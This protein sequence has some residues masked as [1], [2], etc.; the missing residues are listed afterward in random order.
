M[1]KEKTIY[2]IIAVICSILFLTDIYLTY[3]MA[4]FF[5]VDAFENTWLPELGSILIWLILAIL[6]YQKVRYLKY[7]LLVLS[8]WITY[9]ILKMLPQIVQPAIQTRI[10][11]MFALL[12]TALLFFE[13]YLLFKKQP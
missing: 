13:I 9:L 12:C 6:A 11:G 4:Q 10:G 1:L 2:K 8:P 3:E 5:P 7:I